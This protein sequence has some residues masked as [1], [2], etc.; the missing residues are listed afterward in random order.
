MQDRLGR[1]L[2][3]RHGEHA[4][5]RPLRNDAGEHRQHHRDRGGV[6]AVVEHDVFRAE[7]HVEGRTQLRRILQIGL[8]RAG[9]EAVQTGEGAEVGGVEHVADPRDRLVSETGGKG[10]QQFLL[11][12]EMVVE[13]A[14]RNAG[15][16]DDVADRRALI[17]M[18][19][20]QRL[21]AVE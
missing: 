21:R 10:L 20:E 1:I 13:A 6:D 11:R 2:R 3:L 5:G 18:L 14:L 19:E 16:G 17:T 7:H 12:G 4:L 15:L 9:E 8:A